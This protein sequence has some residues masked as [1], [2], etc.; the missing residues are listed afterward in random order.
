M[1]DSTQFCLELKLC[2]ADIVLHLV[3]SNNSI[4]ISPN[5]HPIPAVARSEQR[6]KIV[7]TNVLRRSFVDTLRLLFQQAQWYVSVCCVNCLVS[8]LT[9]NY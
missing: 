3:S 7:S 9:K 5:F 8:T 2:N 1:H 6:F 4:Q